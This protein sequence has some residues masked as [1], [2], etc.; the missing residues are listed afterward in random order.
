MALNT[1]YQLLDITSVASGGSLQMATSGQYNYALITGG[2]SITGGITVAQDTAGVIG[3]LYQAIVTDAI[4]FGG[5]GSFT[6]FGQS[7][8]EVYLNAGTQLNAINNGAGYTVWALPSFTQNGFI[9]GSDLADGTLPLTKLV[10]LTSG[11]IIVG[12]GS[13]IPTAV[14]MSGDATISNSGALTIAN[15]AVTASKIISDAVITA[16]IRDNAVT[17]AKLETAVQNQLNALS[18][19][20]EAVSLAPVSSAS[21]LTLHSVPIDIVPAVSGQTY[22]ATGGIVNYTYNTT[23]Y[24]TATKIQVKTAGASSA[25]LEC[26]I[27]GAAGSMIMPFTPVTVAASSQLKSNAALQLTSTVD[28]TAGDGTWTYYVFYKTYNI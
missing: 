16:K 21:T 22:Q 6:F 3:N 12:N 11:Q 20:N 18:L 14:A 15:N 8:A 13:N 5:G 2:G 9:Q 7:I 27:L 10:N 1:S 19:Q 28:P 17:L 23:P 26:D 4:T 25:Q 24:A